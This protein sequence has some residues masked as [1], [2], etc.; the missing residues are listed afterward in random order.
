MKRETMRKAV[1]ALTEPQRFWLEVLLETTLA[2]AL[3]SKAT[4]SYKAALRKLQAIRTRP[5]PLV[6]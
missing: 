4:A 3:P 6:K 5:R 1:L 2:A